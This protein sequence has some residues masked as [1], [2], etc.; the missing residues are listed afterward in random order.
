MRPRACEM[1]TLLSFLLSAE[2]SS[3]KARQWHLAPAQP[4][5]LGDKCPEAPTPS[6][7][8]QA[9][10]A[11]CRARDLAHQELNLPDKEQKLSL[12]QGHM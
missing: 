12:S 5:V 8:H 9:P 10:M 2:G 4:L 6:P 7:I 11:G 3:D 1:P